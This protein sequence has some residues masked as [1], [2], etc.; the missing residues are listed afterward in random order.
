MG[1]ILEFLA[2]DAACA[3]SSHLCVMVISLICC[4]MFKDFL[5]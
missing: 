3:G 4:Q 2:Q 5:R 1:S